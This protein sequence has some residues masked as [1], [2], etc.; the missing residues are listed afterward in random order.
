MTVIASQRVWSRADDAWIT[1]LV[2][3]FESTLVTCERSVCLQE[4]LQFHQH[5]SWLV[6][7]HLNTIYLQH[8]SCHPLIMSAFPLGGK[9]MVKRA[10]IG[11]LC[12]ELSSFPCASCREPCDRFYS[13]H[14]GLFSL[15]PS[16][17]ASDSQCALH[18]IQMS[19]SVNVWRGGG[20]TIPWWASAHW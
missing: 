15:W 4:K 12:S 20:V 9:W 14:V 19:V 5:F 2:V 7:F 17:K 11:P 6:V 16:E 13:G 3:C 10:T 1:A 8:S 18:L